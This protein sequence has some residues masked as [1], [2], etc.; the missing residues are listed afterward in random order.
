M[1]SRERLLTVLRG[2]VPD[3]VPVCP[4]ISNMVPARLTGKP[5]SEI[6][7]YQNLHALERQRKTGGGGRLSLTRE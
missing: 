4:D 1:T 6:Y 2:E 3:G 7:V 5:F